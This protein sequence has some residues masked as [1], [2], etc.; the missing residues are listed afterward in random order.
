[1]KT[2]TKFVQPLTEEQREQLK[3]VMKSQSPQ[4]TRMRA[5]VILL[6]ERRYSIDQI[7]DIYQVDRDRVSEWLDWW[8]ESQFE[9]L[10]DDPRSGRPPKLTEKEQKQALKLTLKEPRSLRQGLS[11]IASKV[12]KI[13]S[14]DTLKRILTVEDYGWKRVRR[15]LRSLRDEA[16]F[17]TA[18]A[19][20]AALR[21][22]ALEPTRQFDL[23]YFDEA[24]FTLTPCVPYA[25]QK[26]GQTLE[27]ASSHSP[28]QNILGFFN[29]QHEFHSFAFEGAIDTQTVIHCFNLFRQQLER[30][31]VVVVDNAPIHTS[32][33]FAEQKILWQAQDLAV[34][35]IPPYCPEL[36]LIEILWRKIKYEWLPLN[37]YQNFK[38]MTRALFEVLRGIGPKYR[39]TFA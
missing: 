38:A 19:E 24:G 34:K 20:L 27:L 3:E 25:W 16:E 11:A 12:G 36:N 39:I 14:R 6:S 33:D 32:N 22:E 31:A 10:D 2:P 15:S 1:M 30:P 23:W 28:R 4:R 37:A 9:G 26:V 13:I 7:T 17:R 21:T 29:L 5:H 18:Q 35:F 8:E